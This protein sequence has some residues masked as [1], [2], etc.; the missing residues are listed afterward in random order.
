MNKMPWDVVVNDIPYQVVEIEG[1]VHTLG[2]RNSENNLWMYPRSEDPTYEN[3][4]EF[5]C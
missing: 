2:P 3:L 1:Y 4:V 5:S